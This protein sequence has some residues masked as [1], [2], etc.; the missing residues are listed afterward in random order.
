MSQ[1]KSIFAC[2][3]LLLVLAGPARAVVSRVEITERVPFAEGMRREG[4]R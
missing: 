3:A 1:G 2:L 4:I